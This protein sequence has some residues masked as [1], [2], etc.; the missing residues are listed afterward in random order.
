METEKL[1]LLNQDVV[2]KEALRKILLAGIYEN[3]TL[4]EGEP[5]NPTRN[6]LLSAAFSDDY[7]PEQLGHLTKTAAEGI[8]IV[9]NAFTKLEEYVPETP[10][11]DEE[12][13]N[14][15]I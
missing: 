13:K 7:T 9:Q 8:R 6:F 3:G 14:N 15:A 10:K 2:M 12:P 11:K 1:I 4:K 5:A